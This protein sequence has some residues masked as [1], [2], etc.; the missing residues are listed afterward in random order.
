[1]DVEKPPNAEA[2]FQM[3]NQNFLSIIPNPF[4]KEDY[5]QYYDDE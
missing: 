4:S 3:F 1:M 5:D 2:V